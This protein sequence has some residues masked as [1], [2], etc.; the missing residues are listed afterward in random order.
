[1]LLSH[2]IIKNV[3]QKMAFL[4]KPLFEDEIVILDSEGREIKEISIL[5]SFANSEYRDLLEI[6]S[7][8]SNGDIFHTNSIVLVTSEI[9]RKFPFTRTGQLLVCLR[10]LN[11][12][13]LIDPHS[14]KVAW[15]MPG[16]WRWPHDPDFL[17]NGN[18]LIFDN[19]WKEPVRSRVVEFDPLTQKIVWQYQGDDDKPLYSF[20]RSRQ[21]V[22]PN[23]N[24]LICESNGGRLVEV[25]REGEIV[26]EFVNPV[27]E[28]YEGQTYIP[29]ISTGR[30]YSAKELPFLSE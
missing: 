16:P 21:Q 15:I 30:R 26:W 5:E 4:P 9:S 22:L 2:K 1:M 24:I 11:T 12:L 25:N 8:P 13:A 28:S 14:E 18:M 20:I 27:Q 17:E 6:F 23:G 3:P 19:L 29:V 10:N 7:V